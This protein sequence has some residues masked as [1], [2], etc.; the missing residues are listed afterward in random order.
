MRSSVGWKLEKSPELFKNASN[1]VLDVLSVSVSLRPAHGRDG[2]NEPWGK[3][4]EKTES[5]PLTNETNATKN[6]SEL[7]QTTEE[8]VCMYVRV[9]G[10]ERILISVFAKWAE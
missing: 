4:E 10:R 6:T 2:R 8:C 5:T 3:K 1:V 7:S 9:S